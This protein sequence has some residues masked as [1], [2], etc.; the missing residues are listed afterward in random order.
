MRALLLATLVAL[1]LFLPGG[2]TGPALPGMLGSQDPCLVL[3]A[4]QVLE[5]HAPPRIVHAEVDGS[6]SVHPCADVLGIPYGGACFVGDIQIVITG[7][8]DP[9]ESREVCHLTDLAVWLPVDCLTEG[10]APSFGEVT[11]DCY[12]RFLHSVDNAVPGSGIAV[13]TGTWGCY[14]YEEQE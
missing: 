8:D 6:P 4:P 13:A 5:C 1:L 7:I 3:F 10:T 11:L 12:A 14:L 2:L 9:V